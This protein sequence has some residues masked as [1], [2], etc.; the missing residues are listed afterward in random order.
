MQ[1]TPKSGA[2]LHQILLR[3]VMRAPQSFFDETDS[4]VTLNRFSQDMTLIDGSLPAAAVMTLSSKQLLV[5]INSAITNLI[6]SYLPD[7]SP[8]R[9][10]CSWIIVCGTNM[11]CTTPGCVCSSEG[12]SSYVKADEIPGSGMQKPFI[13]TFCGDNRRSFNNQSIWLAGAFYENQP[14]AP[15]RVTKAI[16]SHVLY[17]KMVE[18]R[19]STHCRFHGRC[20]RHS[21][22]ESYEYNKCWA[23][24][25]FHE[26]GSELQLESLFLHDVLDAVGDIVGS[27]GQSQ[28]F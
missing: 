5:F 3:S 26:C 20:C 10:C 25:C 12:L 2:G 27:C 14:R 21:G 22:I 18:S 11:S 7:L 24:G 1:I 17:S 19:S 9:A 15:R 8:V 4:G 13:Y 23:I 28:E 16:L 6:S